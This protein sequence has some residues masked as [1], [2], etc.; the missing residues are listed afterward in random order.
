MKIERH[1]SEE[2]SVAATVAPEDLRRGDY[3]AV[4]SEIVQLPSFLW[5]ETLPTARDEPVRVHHL[6]TENRVPLKIKAICLPFVFVKQPNSRFQTI[7]VRLTSLVRLE[8]SY[9]KTVWKNLKC[10]PAKPSFL[11]LFER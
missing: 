11:S 9:A 2:S 5:C 6:P 10:P 1:Q 7:D 4:L 3:V 8:K